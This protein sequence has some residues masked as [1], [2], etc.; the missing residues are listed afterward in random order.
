MNRFMSILARLK[1]KALIMVLWRLVNHLT[2]WTISDSLQCSA[3]S[4][5]T[6]G[7]WINGGIGF[8]ATLIL[9]GLILLIVPS[10]DCMKSSVWGQ[11]CKVVGFRVWVYIL[12]I[13]VKH[14]GF[15]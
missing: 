3:V 2:S 6:R 12:P 9:E 11:G 7:V 13:V 15:S 14:E 1:L 8:Y 10:F 4:L 5:G